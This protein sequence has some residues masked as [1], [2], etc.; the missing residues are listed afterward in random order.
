MTETCEKCRFWKRWTT[1]A[2]K[3]ECCKKSPKV[4]IDGY[5]IG[6]AGILTAWSEILC[7]DWCGEWEA[8]E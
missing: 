3:G 1:D 4:I 5:E 2:K 7:T 8:K 6:V